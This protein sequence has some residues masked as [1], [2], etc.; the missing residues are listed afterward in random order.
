MKGRFMKKIYFFIGLLFFLTGCSIGLK[1]VIVH[2][3]FIDLKDNNHSEDIVI[4]GSID[5]KLRVDLYIDFESSKTTDTCFGRS[6]GWGSYK[7]FTARTSSFGKDEYRLSLPTKWEDS[8]GENVCDYHIFRVYMRV[9]L[10]KG[11]KSHFTDLLFASNNEKDFV[12]NSMPHFDL[13]RDF[14]VRY[15]TGIS[16]LRCES[17]KNTN[18]K[19]ICESGLD[20]SSIKKSDTIPGSLAYGITITLKNE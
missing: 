5:P 20:K 10:P 13:A 15:L 11:D 19:L 9:S 12:V 3:S 18:F 1:P 8:L 2:K 4:Y 16:S 6:G 14:K 7:K 17:S